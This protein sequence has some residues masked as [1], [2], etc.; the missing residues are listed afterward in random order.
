MN[1]QQVI[2]IGSSGHSKVIIDI[3]E[4]TQQYTLL[5]LLDATRKPGDETMGY[6]VL[7]KEED[8]PR[9][10]N[11]NAGCQVIVAIGD[12]WVR[13]KV[14]NNVLAI[15]PGISFASAI[16]PSAQ[17]ARNVVIGKGVAIMP[18]AIINSDTLIGDFT[19]INTKASIDHD[20]EM[21]GFSSLGPNA[22]IGGRVTI[23]EG[24]AVSISA[25][26]IH[27]INIG[28][29]SLIG[30]GAVLME[31]CDDYMVMHGVPAQKIRSREPG[32][33]YL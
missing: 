1:K 5:G 19:I 22:T 20:G 32:E 10:I 31:D 26:V 18:G 23:G 28:R 9:L 16:H 27:N 24:S 14:V 30:A 21:S 3:F 11:E 15:M 17:I 29:H 8:L 25:T 4:K 7:G 33:K 13:Q 12:N 2:I 6:K